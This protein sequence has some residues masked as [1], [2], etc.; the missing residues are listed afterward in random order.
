MNERTL[1]PQLEK[2]L[3]AAAERRVARSAS[4]ASR[5]RSGGH[6]LRMLGI[7]FASFAIVGTAMAAVGVWNPGIGNDAAFSSPPAINT[8][9][10]PAAVTAEIGALRREPVAAD[11]SPAVEATLGQLGNSGIANIRLD[12]VRF[13]EESVPGEATILFSG[14]ESGAGKKADSVCLGQPGNSGEAGSI[15]FG[16]GEIMAGNFLAA[17]GFHGSDGEETV[18]Q[19]KAEGIV[20]DGVASLTVTMAEGVEREIPVHDNYFH[21]TWDSSEAVAGPLRVTWRD[22]SGAVVPMATDNTVDDQE[23]AVQVGGRNR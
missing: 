11:R 2:M 20:P 14:E 7:G 17:Q 6:I 10:I 9:P 21:F 15:C 4:S 5:A 19:G 18:D 22:A 3:S 8:S 13:L 12:S 16:L 1:T 23:G